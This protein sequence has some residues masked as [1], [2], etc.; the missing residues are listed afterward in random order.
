MIKNPSITFEILF[1]LL[2]MYFILKISFRFSYIYFVSIYFI[3]G[4]FLFIV[5]I[6]I[7]HF[8]FYLIII[9][10]SNLL[11]LYILIIS[12]HIKF[13]NLIFHT[14][15]IMVICFQ[16]YRSKNYHILFLFIRNIYA[17]IFLISYKNLILFFFFF[18]F[19]ISKFL[20]IYYPLIH[21]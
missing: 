9:E 14:T 4:F 2:F 15:I 1:Y 6:T 10:L 17:N 11:F 8:I 16:I 19:C 21:Y 7:F 3:F 18:A 20:S 13:F 12:R 5:V